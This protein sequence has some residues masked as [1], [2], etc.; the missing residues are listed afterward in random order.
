M[1]AAEGS[2]LGLAKQTAKGTPNTTDAEFKYFLFNEGSF[3]VNTQN[4]PLDPEVGGGA[5][6][7][8]VNKVGVMS[9][10]ALTF[11][12][13]PSTL[14]NLLLG[15]LPDVVTVD[16]T[17]YYTHTFTLGTD[18]FTAPYYTM[19]NAPGNLWGEQ[20]QDSRVASL[21]LAWRGSNFLRGQVGLMGGLPAKVATAA[22][23]PLTYLDTGPQFLTPLSKIEVP[24]ATALKVLSG[25]FA[26]ANNIPLDEQWVVGSY[27]PDGFD[28]TGKSFVLSL[29][30]K[31][32][33]ADLYTKINYDPAGGSAWVAD[34]FKEAN[35]DIQFVSNVEVDTGVPYS[36]AI[37]ANGQTGDNAN[38]AWTAQPIPVRSQRNLMMQVTGTFLASPTADTPVTVTLINDQAS[39]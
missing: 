24:D 13:R 35:L 31:V 30:V 11:I 38:V 29:V 22:W 18:H 17:T 6:L 33:D 16:N 4:L 1:T 23:D 14:G 15:V 27:Q 21:A 37:N 3:G 10:G 5:L 32:D 25:S 9:G 28:I 19:R 7:R 26:A 34:I 39:Y 20:M 8:D 2:Y 36:V 12:P